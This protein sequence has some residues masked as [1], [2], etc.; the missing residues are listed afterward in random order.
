MTLA[1]IFTQIR[2][3]FRKTR[4][5]VLIRVTPPIIWALASAVSSTARLRVENEAELRQ[6]ERDHLPSLAVTWH[7]RTLLPIY[8]F[9]PRNW[10]AMI[11]MSRDGEYQSRIFARFGWGVVR[12]S[13]GRGAVRAL[14]AAVRKL[15]AGAT[16]A[17]TPDG[18]RGPSHAVQPG[19][20]YLSQKLGCPIYPIGVSSYP[21][22]FLPTWDNYQIPLPFCRSAI[23]VGPPLTVPST[24]SEDQLQAFAD[25]LALRICDVENRAEDIVTP[26]SRRRRSTPHPGG[27]VR[28]PE[29]G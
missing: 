20:L 5:E 22:I 26:P 29:P 21:R 15:R 7:G 8:R 27:A 1:M 23:V 24:D 17:F 16:F 10:V 12:G 3:W 14:A 19:V 9:G 18:P 2:R 11:S 13:T 28:A 25:E 6:R 4:G